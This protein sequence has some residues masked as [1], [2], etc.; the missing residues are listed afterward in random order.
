MQKGATTTFFFRSDRS[1]L[2]STTTVDKRQL[3]EQK[4]LRRLGFQVKT[5]LHECD[6]RALHTQVRVAH[7]ALIDFPSSARFRD[8]WR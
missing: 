4:V 7:L 2:Y 8:T 6:L 3:P 5:F 1:A